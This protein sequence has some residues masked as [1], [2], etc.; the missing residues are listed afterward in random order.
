LAAHLEAVG[1]PLMEC[2]VLVVGSGLTGATIARLVKDEGVSV[3]VVERRSHIGGNVHDHRHHSGIA[4]H[5][6]GPHYFRTSS[7]RIWAFVNRFSSF[8]PFAATL[9]T[10][11][12]GR[13]ENWPI[14]AEYIERA[15]GAEW[16]PDFSGNPTNFEEACL[17]MMPRPVYEQFVKGYTEKQWGVPA[18]RLDATLAGRFDVRTDNDPR[19]KTSRY[20]GVPSDGYGTLMGRLLAGIPVVSN[21]EYLPGR[22]T[23]APRLLTVYTGAIDE[24]FAFDLGRLRYRG[25]R[26]EEIWLAGER[27]RHPTVQTNFPSPAQGEFIREIE[28]KH[29]MDPA[30]LENISGTLITREYPVTPREPDRFEY[31]M[32]TE[33]DRNL[34]G[35]YARRAETIPNLLI[36]GRLGEYRYFDMD[37]AIGRAFVLFERKV[38]PQIT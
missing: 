15:I 18:T 24:F 30:Q 29:M 35:Q 5:T 32:P 27:Y 11:V 3:A 36:C 4:V 22:S 26:R 37:Q 31:P 8:R 23:I 6:Y 28:W 13:Y 19:L 10:L 7:D 34:F 16:H 1:V 2:D 20:Q 21:Y 12:N 33:Q 9:K 14:S 25:Q 38:K 17:A